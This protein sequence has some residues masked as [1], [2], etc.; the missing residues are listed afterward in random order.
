MNP[1][2]IQARLANETSVNVS[3]RTIKRYLK[4]LNLKLLRNDVTHGKVSIQQVYDAIHDAQT[5]RLQ[6]NAGYQRMRMIL[7]REYDIQIPQRLVYD[8]LREIDPEDMAA[9]LRG[10][11]KRQTYQTNGPNH[12]WS[13]DGHD[14][15]KRF[16]LTIYGYVNAWSR[17]ILGMFV[18]V[19]NNDPRHIAVHFLQLA[20]EA[21][22]IPLLLTTDCGTETHVKMARCMMELTYT[23]MEISLEDAA[24][25]MH[26]T[27]ST[28]N[29]KIESL[30]SQ[31]MKQHNRAIKHN[32]LSHIEDG[33][34]DDQDDVQKL[35]FL[36]L[37]VPV[38]QASVDSWVDTYNNYQKRRDHLTTLPTG[39]SSEFAYSTPEYFGTTNQL[40]KMPSSDI[41]LMLQTD[42]PN[43]DLLFA[44][45]PLDFHEV[46]IEVMGNLD[47][48][49]PGG[50]W[51]IACSF[52]TINST[53]FS[54][55]SLSLDYPNILQLINLKKHWGNQFPKRLIQNNEVNCLDSLG[56]QG[57]HLFVSPPLKTSSS[58]PTWQSEVGTDYLF[59]VGL[60]SHHLSA[61]QVPNPQERHCS[62]G[63]N[64]KAISLV[65]PPLKTSYQSAQHLLNPHVQPGRLLR[66]DSKAI[67]LVLNL[68]KRQGRSIGSDSLKS[69]H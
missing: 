52:L 54:N 66:S 30:W 9:R 67:L 17:K 64:S 19:T 43:L 15:L 20:S 12:I 40:L 37:W 24:K 33:S 60:I 11:C 27:K 18:H 55:I 45:T 1:N 53:G 29:Q 8:V 2:K 31:M 42:Y 22:G 69:A 35:L 48:Q 62:L 13:S 47:H 34:Y 32:I 7:M 4:Q 46:A 14:K 49:S 10:V 59:A 50:T 57:S 58:V 38:L 39:V 65:I 23:H 36:F 5:R 68:R 16:G 61:Q 41:N 56:F 28:H 6:S 21:G 63:T 44:H 26:Y 3:I 25:R 51:T